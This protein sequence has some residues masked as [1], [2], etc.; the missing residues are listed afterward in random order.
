MEHVFDNLSGTASVV[1]IPVLPFVGEPILLEAGGAN[2]DDALAQLNV[3]SDEGGAVLQ[4]TGDTQDIVVDESGILDQEATA[5]PELV[6]DMERI[7]E[8][9]AAT[10]A[11]SAA[12]IDLD[13][14]P[15]PY[16]TYEPIMP[17]DDGGG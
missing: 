5:K 1:D 6:L 8:V 2:L 11:L 3:T 14:E 13:G 4:P 9:S 17:G 15:E 10:A 12:V 16:F 7:A